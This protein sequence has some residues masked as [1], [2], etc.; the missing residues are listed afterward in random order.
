MGI[1]ENKVLK[2]IKD[3]IIKTCISAEPH[4]FNAMNRFLIISKI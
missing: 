3:V 4:V 2:R 1:N